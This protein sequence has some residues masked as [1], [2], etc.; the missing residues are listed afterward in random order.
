MPRY[1]T[2]IYVE[3]TR[4]RE[5]VEKWLSATMAKLP[6]FDYDPE[7]EEVAED[8]VCTPDTLETHEPT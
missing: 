2:T 6:D 7:W 8:M 3:T 4:S 1:M 5:A